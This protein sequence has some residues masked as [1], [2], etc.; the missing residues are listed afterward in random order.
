MTTS[1]RHAIHLD[2]WA[3][4]GNEATL[5]HLRAKHGLYYPSEADK[6][7]AI[8]AHERLHQ[9]ED[10]TAPRQHFV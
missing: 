6:L 1:T 7:Q 3:G 5:A 9:I 4:L 2:I 8:I 10:L